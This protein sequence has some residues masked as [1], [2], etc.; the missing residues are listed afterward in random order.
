MKKYELIAGLGWMA[1]GVIFLIGSISLGFGSLNEPGPG[2]FPFL[3]A[4]F[5]TSF[6]SIDLIICL[7]KGKQ[8]DLVMNKKFW[9]ES[10]DAKKILFTIIF[11]FMFVVGLKYMGFI[12]TTIIFMVS[13][14]KLIEPQ[15]WFTVLIIGSLTTGLSYLI[16]QIWLKANL[17]VGFL[18]F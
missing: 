5:L 13:L 11:L 1:A 9:P 10:Y 14:L 18:G 17:P 3:M 16:F 12:F 15:K 6:S 8:L 2:F 4:V 7:R